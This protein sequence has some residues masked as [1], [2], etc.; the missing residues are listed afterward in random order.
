MP[1][2]IYIKGPMGLFSF[3]LTI[4]LGATAQSSPHV[5]VTSSIYVGRPASISINSIQVEGVLVD[6]APGTL[7]WSNRITPVAIR[8]PGIDLA[9]GL[10]QDIAAEK[11]RAFNTW[12]AEKWIDRNARCNSVFQR[13]PKHYPWEGPYSDIAP[14]CNSLNLPPNDLSPACSAPTT[15]SL[16]NGILRLRWLCTLATNT[17]PIVYEEAIASPREGT[18]A[19]A[20]NPASK[21][22]SRIPI[23]MIDTPDIEPT[24]VRKLTP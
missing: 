10:F 21:E 14:Q 17:T 18:I 16:S 20:I 11:K 1:R 24:L 3:L 7:P 4:C 6:T 2:K 9:S 8:Y 15:A 5:H 19:A 12:L 23:K 22:R 13:D